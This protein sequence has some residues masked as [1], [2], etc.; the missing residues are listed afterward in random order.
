MAG[1]LVNRI[2]RSVPLVLLITL[3]VYGLVFLIPGDP[4]ATLAGDNPT[5]EQIAHI[6]Q[7]LGLDR[8]AVE[9][10]L[11]WL[12]DAVRGQLGQSLYTGAD[13][14]GMILDRF[15]VTAWLS[16]LAVLVAVVIGIPAGVLAAAARG[17]WIDRAITVAVTA[18]IAI[19]GFWLG[20]MLIIVFALQAGVFPAGGYTPI[21]EDFGEWLLHV[22]LPAV[23]LA[24]APAAELARHTRS[25]MLGV[26]EQ[27]Y[28]RSARAKGVAE[29]AVLIRHGL[30]NAAGPVITVLSFQAALLLGGSV[31]VEQIFGMPGLGSLAIQAVHDKDLP[32]LQGVVLVAALIVMIINL[33]TDLAYGFLNPKVRAV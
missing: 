9:Q 30:K 6:R 17:S 21:S 28:I 10:Y 27:D 1:L 18:G 8:P 2:L 16:V 25:A 5:P 29:W 3:G 20:L 11:G 22:T 19:P 33:L 7:S 15:G 31:I 32:V 23:T 14:T 12:L 24:A 13:V 4:A 26:L